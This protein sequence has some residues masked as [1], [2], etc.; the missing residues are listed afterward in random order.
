VNFS[1]L[2]LRNWKS[3]GIMSSEHFVW[4]YYINVTAS[5]D[6]G[7]CRVPSFCPLLCAQSCMKESLFIIVHPLFVLKN[8]LDTLSNYPTRTTQCKQPINL[9]WRH[10][11]MLFRMWKTD[12]LMDLSPTSIQYCTDI[13]KATASDMLVDTF[14]ICSPWYMAFLSMHRPIWEIRLIILGQR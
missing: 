10:L 12:Y 5:W 13:E 3:K 1:H 11:G 2:G 14:W 4:V 9:S 8:W 7:G 6:V